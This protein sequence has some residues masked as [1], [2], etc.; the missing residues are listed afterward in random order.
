MDK[1]YFFWKHQFGQW[2]LRDMQD[3]E[4]IVY[5]C[6]EQYMMAQKARL[7]GDMTAFEKIMVEKNP[8]EQ[9]K[10]GRT[11][12][13][14][15]ENIWVGNREII[16]YDG[17]TLKFTQHEDLGKR[18]IATHPAILVEASP[19]D[20][21]WGVGLS[22]KDPSILD[23][24]NWKGLNLLGNALMRVREDLIKYG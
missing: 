7:F 11:V 23:E 18:L 20:L 10:L 5:N 14:Y 12:E 15:N 21:V 4:G 24:K 8:E 6:C 19:Y 9:Q 17:N 22:A 13:R 16:V 1:F 3:K 2:T